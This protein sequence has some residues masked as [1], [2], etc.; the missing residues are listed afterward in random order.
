[1]A[2]MF[3]DSS[4]YSG[5]SLNRPSSVSA[6]GRNWQQTQGGAYYDPISGRTISNPS[7]YDATV[8]QARALSN[9]ASYN[10]GVDYMAA[11]QPYLQSATDA[12]TRLTSTM[13][14]NDYQA[15]LTA[16]LDNPDSISNTGAY[17]FQFNQGQKALERSA[18][19]RGMLGSG[20]TLASLVNYG[21]GAASQ[22]YNTEAD[23][24]AGLV[25]QNQNYTTNIA[26]TLAD[27]NLSAG[28][29]ALNASKAKADDYWNA[30]NQALNTARMSNYY[31][32]I[33]W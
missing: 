18:A 23:R 24:L 15:R 3:V 17:K 6:G 29:V 7:G 10:T 20:N 13:P 12:V 8:N 9:P 27:I 31:N 19:A 28:N 30:N 33:V 26:K 22:A 5:N 14:T 32:P 11:V 21:Q 4:A 2:L 25:G 16:L 1:M